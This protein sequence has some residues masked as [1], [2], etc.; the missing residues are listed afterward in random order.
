M[1]SFLQNL[2]LVQH[3]VQSILA[4]QKEFNLGRNYKVVSS[5]RDDG[6]GGVA[7]ALHESI[8]YEEIDTS[9]FK[10][11]EIVAV[12]ILNFTYIMNLFSVYIPPTPR[13]P[14]NVI[15]AELNNLFYV[16]TRLG[17][18]LLCGDL[19][20]HNRN[21]HSHKSNERGEKLEDLLLEHHL[22]IL[23]DDQ[24]TMIPRAPHQHSVIDLSIATMDLA[25]HFTF[26]VIEDSVGSDHKI[27]LLESRG[28]RSRLATPTR[29][30]RF[31]DKMK[32][33]DEWARVETTGMT[34][35]EFYEQ[36][37]RISSVSTRTK[38]IG[39]KTFRKKHWWCKEVAAEYAKVRQRMRALNRGVTNERIERLK[40][41][42][43]QGRSEESE[44]QIR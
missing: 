19:N 17:G 11:I 42:E 5:P 38:E 33:Q 43:L 35:S 4:R 39:A 21:W 8:V 10:N 20:A 12:R 37:D 32:F 24:M 44:Q 30:V 18:S 41:E 29:P 22:V 13:C 31:F 25:R 14:E 2:R 6:F 16:M 1:D 34:M 3:N 27:I 40:T 36:H 23:N 7:I 28:A 15:E 9:H 26:E